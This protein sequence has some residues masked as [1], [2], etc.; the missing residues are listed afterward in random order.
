MKAERFSLTTCGDLGCAGP[1]MRIQGGG[2]S[3]FQAGWE[4]R[5][6][7]LDLEGAEGVR[8]LRKKCPCKRR[9][10]LFEWL[11]APIILSESDV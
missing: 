5:F 4:A 11:H 1:N 8:S 6:M 7:K 2:S 9:E 10:F 3:E